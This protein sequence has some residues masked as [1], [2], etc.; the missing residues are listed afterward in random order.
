MAPNDVL[1]FEDSGAGIKAARA[2]GMGT[3]AVGPNKKAK[4]LAKYSF[5]SMEKAA[6]A[7]LRA[8]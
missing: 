3:V 8:L 4:C 1:V 6:Q 5:A 7:A 2:A